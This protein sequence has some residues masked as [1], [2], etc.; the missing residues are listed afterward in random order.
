MDMTTTKPLELAELRALIRD[1]KEQG[2]ETVRIEVGGNLFQRFHAATCYC[3]CST[4]MSGIQS[5]TYEYGIFFDDIP[6][7]SIVIPEHK[8]TLVCKMPQYSIDC[9]DEVITI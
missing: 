8:V 5:V 3:Q 9:T 7:M 6:V 2:Y 4:P 1:A